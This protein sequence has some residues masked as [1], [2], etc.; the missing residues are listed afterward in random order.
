MIQIEQLTKRYG[1]TVAVDGLS[2]VVRPGQVT[3]FLGP[4]GSGK[5]TTM[6]IVL[7][8]DAPTSGRALV[9]GRP[10]RTLRHPMRQVGALLDAGAV[11]PQR[12][13][14]AH[15]GWMAASNRLPARR[16][17]DVLEQVGLA[18]VARTPAGEFS[19]GMKQRLGIAAA[20]L[21]DPQVLLFDEPVNGL[22]PEGVRWIRQL[23][24][25]LAAQG[26]TVLLSSHLMSELAQ[27]AQ[28]LVVIGRGRLLA[29]TTV[30]DLTAAHQ[31]GVLVR[32]PQAADLT[33][34]LRA[35]GATVTPW[36]GPQ[37]A[38][39]QQQAS[40]QPGPGWQDPEGGAGQVVGADGAMLVGRLDAARIGE[41]AAAHG[42]P[43]YEV[44]PQRASLEDAYLALTAGSVD[45]R[46]APDP[47]AAAPS[48]PVGRMS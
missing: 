40:G 33:R 30:A 24:R 43:L 7:G 29:H 1:A 45:Y 35:A 48:Y 9:N 21:G 44:T 46:A 32:S 26:R 22:D 13:A 25:G 28:A 39:A 12:T 11:H 34:L 42:I 47:P 18:R 10:Y 5:S 27:T 23:L 19:L 20:L 31:Q 37:Q 2:F 17:P 3:G 36:A 8:L 6:R 4:N 15:L 41:L 38:D 14:A 16:V